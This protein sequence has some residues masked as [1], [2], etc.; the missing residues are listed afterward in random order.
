VESQEI[1]RIWEWERHW[2]ETRGD[3]VIRFEDVFEGV[4]EPKI[5]KGHEVGWDNMADGKV[6]A[7]LRDN[8]TDEER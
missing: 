3:G 5:R 2:V 1:E 7:L 4:V 6:L 8:S